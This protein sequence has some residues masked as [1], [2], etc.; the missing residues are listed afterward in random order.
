MGPDGGVKGSCWQNDS[1]V[2][3]ESLHSGVRELGSSVFVFVHRMVRS[4]ENQQFF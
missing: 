3:I 2:I 4:G 1:F